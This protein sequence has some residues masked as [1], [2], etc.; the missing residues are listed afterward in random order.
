[1]AFIPR[2]AKWYIAEIV[3]EIRVDGETSNV[4]HINTVLVRADSPDDAHAKA[5]DLGRESE[6][7]YS[8]T[9]GRMVSIR[10]RGLADL[11]VVHDGLEHGSELLYR[12]RIGLTEAE[13]QR[14]VTEK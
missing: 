9:Q 10:F 12:E 2:D 7:S 6:I 8:N 3:Q 11:Y 14:L 5:L 13:V 4:V 1:M